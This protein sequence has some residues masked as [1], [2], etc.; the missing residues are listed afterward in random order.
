M[1]DNIVPVFRKKYNEEIKVHLK[2]LFGW[3]NDLAV[4]EI[5]KVVLSIGTGTDIPIKKAIEVLDI[6]AAQK[7]IVRKA[8][9]SIA[10]FKLREGMENGAMVTCRRDKMYFVLQRMFLALLNWRNFGM[11][12]PSSINVAGGKCQI[13]IGIPDATI[14]QGIQADA[15][16]RNIGFSFTIVSNAKKR[17]HFMELLKGFG[18]PFIEKGDE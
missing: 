14:V 11:L 12:K 1:K 3:T 4:P 6:I 10:A 5:Q 13:T 15:S 8:R 2:S 16:V 17:E 7:S 18:F 9:K